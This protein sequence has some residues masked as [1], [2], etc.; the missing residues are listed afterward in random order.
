[1][2]NKQESTL[3]KRRDNR[4]FFWKF[5]QNPL[6]NA[7]ILPTTD[8]A[9]DMIC[10]S[11]QRDLIK[12][13]LELWPWTGPVTKHI[14]AQLH[15]QTQYYGL[16]L[17]KEY[18]EKLQNKYQ[19]SK[20]MQF[21]QWS[22][23]E[24]NKILQEHSIEKVDLVISTLPYM[25][26]SKHPQAILTIKDLTDQGSIFRGISY[27]PPLFNKTFKILQPKIINHTRQNIP[28]VFIHGVN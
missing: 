3:D 26:F 8:K 14:A 12:T 1:M 17:E 18:I 2:R 24:L 16:D 15:E 6:Q 28:Y 7:S 22:I 21:I 4:H 23:A 19:S 9:A 11:I 13:V 27:Y 25:A 5:I 20:N 10:K